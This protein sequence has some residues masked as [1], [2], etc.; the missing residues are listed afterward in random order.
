MTLAA[1]LALY[2]VSIKITSQKKWH[3]IQLPLCYLFYFKSISIPSLIL[4]LLILYGF[5]KVIVE[6]KIS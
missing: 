3:E 1:K 2:I 6:N 5:L 4:Q